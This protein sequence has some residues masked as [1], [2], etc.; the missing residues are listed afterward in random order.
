MTPVFTVA[1][2]TFDRPALLTQAIDSVLA[3]TY[4]DFEIVV[5]DNGSAPST[6]AALEPYLPRIR[7]ARQEN[8]GRA[9][10]RN[11]AIALAR[12][13]YVAFLDDDDLWLPDKLERQSA[14]FER[15]PQAALVH[16]HVEVVDAQ[17]RVLTDLT[18]LHRRLWS[19]AHRGG[20]TYA[21]YALDCRCFTSAAAVPRAL[22]ER[23][24]GYDPSVRLEDV[25]LYLRL[26]LEGAIVFLEGPPLARY[27]YHGAQTSNEELTRGMIDVAHKHLA[28]LRERPDRRAERNFLLSL[29]WSHHVLLEP[30]AVRRYT[31]AALAKDPRGAL[32]RRTLRP[33]IVSL[34]PPRLIARARALPGRAARRATPGGA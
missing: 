27:R 6:R 28:L 18:A 29:A 4:R 16:G 17:G 7:Y 12:G 21:D 11:S 1:I 22:L 25:D 15:A 34:L 14:A 20:A 31:L 23:V 13:R 33:M 5:V 9:G 8:A 10:G 19:D 32:T 30:R 26:A 2:S 3:Q 24:G